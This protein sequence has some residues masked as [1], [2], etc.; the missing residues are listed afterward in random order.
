MQT[1]VR[2]DRQTGDIQLWPVITYAQLAVGGRWRA[3]RPTLSLTGTH[4]HNPIQK[5]SKNKTCARI[6]QKNGTLLFS[7]LQANLQMM[8]LLDGLHRIFGRDT[9]ESVR[10]LRELGMALLNAFPPLKAQIAGFAMGLKLHDQ[11]K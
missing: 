4:T 6:S 10:A 5:V 11:Q 7:S 9:P 3:Y 1:S 8:T 2:V